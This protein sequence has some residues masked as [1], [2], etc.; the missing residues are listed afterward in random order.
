[1]LLENLCKK[2]GLHIIDGETGRSRCIVMEERCCGDKVFVDDFMDDNNTCE[3]FIKD[4]EV[5]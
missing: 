3:D 1:M 2:C 4:K 5:I